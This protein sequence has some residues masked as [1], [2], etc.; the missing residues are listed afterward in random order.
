MSKLDFYLKGREDDLKLLSLCKGALERGA[1]GVVVDYSQLDKAW[2]WLE[3]GSL[4]LA[5]RLDLTSELFTSEETFR[6]IKRAFADGAGA[7]EVARSVG[8]WSS[9]SEAAEFCDVAL[10]AADGRPLVISLEPARMELPAL[11]DAL[12]LLI[13][14]GVKEIK[15]GSGLEGKLSTLPH[16]H[17]ALLEARGTGAKLIFTPA[18][19]EGKY[20]LE[21]AFRLAEKLAPQ[22]DILT[23]SLEWK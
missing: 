12:R 20:A 6:D 1:R 2:K 3:R 15:L 9:S 16:L 11:R 10:E 21:D 23:A 22:E 4:R 7:V 8:V 5:A 14:E 18:A 19:S 17:A 13:A